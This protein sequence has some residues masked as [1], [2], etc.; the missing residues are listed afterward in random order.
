MRT[1]RQAIPLEEVIANMRNEPQSCSK[2]RYSRKSTYISE[3]EADARAI[4]G[5]FIAS[6]IAIISICSALWVVWH[7]IGSAQAQPAPICALSDMTPP[8]TKPL[9]VPRAPSERVKH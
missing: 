1:I 3:S 9:M 7:S 4:I 8:K 5:V 2:N 6:M